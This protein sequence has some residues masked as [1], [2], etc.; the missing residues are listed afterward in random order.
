MLRAAVL[1]WPA[2]FRLPDALLAV[3][4]AQLGRYALWLPVC[5]G[6]GTLGYF[7]LRTEPPVWAG[8]AVFLPAATTSNS[9]RKTGHGRASAIP[10]AAGRNTASPAQTGGSVRRAK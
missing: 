10:Q 9:P 4:D 8:L 3:L 6:S 7:A 2:R 5:M 1:A